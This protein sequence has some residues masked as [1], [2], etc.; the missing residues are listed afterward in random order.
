MHSSSLESKL[1][2]GWIG[3]QSRDF[4]DLRGCFLWYL[5]PLTRSSSFTNATSIVNYTIA[6][7]EHHRN[8]YHDEVRSS[9]L[10]I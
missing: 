4:G 7:T 1:S 3:P 2:A 9:F 5:Q 6:D 10:R 8:D